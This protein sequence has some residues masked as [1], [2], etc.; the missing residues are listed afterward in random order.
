MKKI[1]IILLTLLL[2]G[3]Y[4]YV[5]IDDIGVV[6]GLI[7]DYIDSKYEITSQIIDNSN[8]N[9]IKLYTTTCNQLSECI[10]EISIYS[11][12][13]IFMSHLKV[14]ILT[15]SLINEQTKYYDYFLRDPKSKMNFYVYSISNNDKKEFIKQIETYSLLDLKDLTDI[16]SKELSSSY[17]LNFLDL[18]YKELEPGIE[19]IYPSIAISDNKINLNGLKSYSIKRIDLNNI[20]SITY[21]ILTNNI[22]NASLEIPC[23]TEYFTILINSTK[24]K[25]KW[26]D[27]KFNFNIKLNSNITNY[28]CKYNL[29]NKETTKILSNHINQYIKRNVNHILQLSKKNEFDFIG[30]GNYIYKHDKNYFDFDKY[31]WNHKLKDI[32]VNV[33]VDATINSIGESKI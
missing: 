22:T 19:I 27:E 13:Q 8:D 2:T 25:Y 20:D 33:K 1:I 9:N 6:S 32:N 4:D 17:K 11:N 15:D 14:L 24:T 18:I 5:E 31:N 12:K 16:N 21:N 28:N 30:I 7:I 29:T 3:C 10:K 23:E 26:K